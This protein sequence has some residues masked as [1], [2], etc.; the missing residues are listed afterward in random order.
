MQLFDLNL[1]KGSVV[2]KSIKGANG[3]YYPSESESL[4]VSEDC[5]AD[6]KPGWLSFKGFVPVVVPSSSFETRLRYDSK[7]K[8]VVWVSSRKFQNKQYKRR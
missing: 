4:V 7:E 5:E 6:R 3:F 1:R 2:F 8:M